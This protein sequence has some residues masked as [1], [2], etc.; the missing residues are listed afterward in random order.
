ML[1][2]AD[3]N[4]ATLRAK[5][6][7]YCPA[8]CQDGLLR[9]ISPSA[10]WRSFDSTSSLVVA[11]ARRA[12]THLKVLVQVFSVL[13]RTANLKPFPRSG[14]RLHAMLPVSTGVPVAVDGMDS[15]FDSRRSYPGPGARGGWNALRD[16]TE[17]ERTERGRGL[18]CAFDKQGGFCQANRSGYIAARNAG[19]A[20]YEPSQAGHAAC[21]TETKRSCSPPSHAC[22][23]GVPDGRFPLI[24]A[25]QVCPNW[26]NTRVAL[27]FMES[28]DPDLLC[29]LLKHAGWGERVQVLR[30]A[31]ALLTRGITRA[32]N[33]F[34]RQPD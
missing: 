2:H 34:R 18:E 11:V 23:L 33:R 27:A 25:D 5:T 12:G 6:L 31:E 32:S 17:A 30:L 14:R 16:R 24:A 3:A 28:A 21:G 8:P 10:S 29:G 13:Q 22:R 20:E 9:P 26:L 19:G 4:H 7:C 15:R 1:E